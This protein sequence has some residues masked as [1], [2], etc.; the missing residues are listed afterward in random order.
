M[1]KAKIDPQPIKNGVGKARTKNRL[2]FHSLRHSF[3]SMLANKGIASEVR[4]Q[5]TGHSSDAMNQKY[6][7]LELERLREAVSVIPNL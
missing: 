6:T 5:L 4:Q 2:S 3:N 7:H 1:E